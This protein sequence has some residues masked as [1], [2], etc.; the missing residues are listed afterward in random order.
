[1]KGL[2][3]FKII[4]NGKG[5]IP[6]S[7]FAPGWRV[8]RSPARDLPCTF[9]SLDNVQTE[10][11][12]YNGQF[13]IQEESDVSFIK[14]Y[15]VLKFEHTIVSKVF[16]WTSLCTRKKKE[17][18]IVWFLY[19]C[20]HTL[21]GLLLLFSEDQFCQINV[22]KFMKI[23]DQV[24][25]YVFYKWGPWSYSIFFFLWL[26]FFSLRVSSCIWNKLFRL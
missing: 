6:H 12:L 23:L 14:I 16:L 4:P 24:Q 22:I 20:R 25:L 19:M 21:V 1:M 2:H 17:K 13:C 9:N 8:L 3:K 15:N 10:H 18:D 5:Q 26:V 7:Y 11:I